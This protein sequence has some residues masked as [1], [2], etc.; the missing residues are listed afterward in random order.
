MAAIA[1]HIVFSVK[2][3]LTGSITD[4]FCFFA[5]ALLESSYVA[6]RSPSTITLDCSPSRSLLSLTLLV[7][8]VMAWRYSTNYSYPSMALDLEPAALLC[9][10]GAGSLL[11]EGDSISNPR[12]FTPALLGKEPGSH[13]SIVGGSTMADN[14]LDSELSRDPLRIL[15][16]IL[17]D[18]TFGQ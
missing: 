4:S 10:L 9:S 8:L 16:F 14:A 7:T 6:S 13:K 2:E 3:A 11:E 15:F 12:L 17:D 1:P 18:H 5:S